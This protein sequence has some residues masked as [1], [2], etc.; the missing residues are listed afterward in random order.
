MRSDIP[1]QEKTIE[2]LSDEAFV[3]IV[4][5]AETTAR[6]MNVTLTCLIEHP[7]ILSRLRQELDQVV[8]P[9]LA[10]SRDLENV[11]FMK[12]V[13]QEGI[14]MATP[15][16]NRPILRAINEDLRCNGFIIPRGVRQET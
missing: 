11:P 6:V 3:L 7:E 13:I 9:G 1:D 16:T 10:P 5:G 12:A 2:R 15:V 14:R 4:A 8:N